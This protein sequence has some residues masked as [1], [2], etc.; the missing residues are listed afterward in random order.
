MDKGI[1]LKKKLNNLVQNKKPKKQIKKKPVKQAIRKT[2][3]KNTTQKKSINNFKIEKINMDNFCESNNRL[4]KKIHVFLSNSKNIYILMNTIKIF[5]HPKVQPALLKEIKKNKDKIHNIFENFEIVIEYYKNN[6]KILKSDIGHFILYYEHNL[7]KLK[8][9][10]DKDYLNFI[11]RILNYPN[12]ISL[13]K[14]IFYILSDYRSCIYFMTPN[15]KFRNSNKSTVHEFT[16]KFYNN[17]N[18]CF[19]IIS[20]YYPYDNSPWGSYY[21]GAY[22]SFETLMIL[23]KYFKDPLKELKIGFK[24]KKKNNNQYIIKKISN[25]YNI[26]LN[27]SDKILNITNFIILMKKLK[28]DMHEVINIVFNI[29][30]EGIMFKNIQKCYVI[31]GIKIFSQKKNYELG[32]KIY[33]L[34]CNGYISNVNCFENFIL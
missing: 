5:S 20:G 31:N 29:I 12:L 30:Y 4:F 10:D 22:A 6:N 27:K 26:K 13:L 11:H 34:V 9:K 8:I 25:I 7:S 2:V 19:S 28:Y 21:T 32:I 18:M 15:I 1:N 33:L 23:K 17:Q 3:I 14:E 24:Y 16:S